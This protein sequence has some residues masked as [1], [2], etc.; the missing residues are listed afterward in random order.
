MSW[1][2]RTP[3]LKEPPKK[4]PQRR[5]SPCT[6]KQLKEASEKQKQQNAGENSS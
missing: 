4:L 5:S 3:R 1:Y 2:K 6:E